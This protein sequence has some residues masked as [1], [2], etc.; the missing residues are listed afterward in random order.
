MLSSEPQAPVTGQRKT[1]A[2]QAQQTWKQATWHRVDC[3]H[4]ISVQTQT[5]PPN[6]HSLWQKARCTYLAAAVDVPMPPQSLPFKPKKHPVNTL[7]NGRPRM[8]LAGHAGA[9]T[10]MVT[11][12]T[13]T[14]PSLW[15]ATLQHPS[16]AMPMHPAAAQLEQGLPGS[17][18]HMQDYR[19]CKV[20][21]TPYI[22][23]QPTH[24]SCCKQ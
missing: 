18:V 9:Y 17:I 11:I 2:Q 4:V 12:L 13:N 23:V 22:I 6:Q 16:A 15:T 14:S 8:Q 19:A 20:Q 24:R 1:A 7:P 21:P 3:S 10:P 5:R